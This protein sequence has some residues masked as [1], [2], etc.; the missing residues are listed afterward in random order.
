MPS[1]NHKRV[2]YLWINK[3]PRKRLLKSTFVSFYQSIEFVVMFIR[4]S[5]WEITQEEI[6][7]LEA[8]PIYDYKK[9]LVKDRRDF[10]LHG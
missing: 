1:F 4:R 6:F 8:F 9:E 10:H 3:S 7:S 2:I 5:V